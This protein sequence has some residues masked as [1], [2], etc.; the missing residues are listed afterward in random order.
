[1]P[2][3]KTY[4]TLLLCLLLIVIASNLQTGWIFLL[5]SYIFV[6]ILLSFFENKR[7]IKDVYVKRATSVRGEAGKPHPFIYYVKNPPLIFSIKEESIS[8]EFSCLSENIVSVEIPLKRGIYELNE[9]QL[10]TAYPSGWF[11]SLKTINSYKRITIWP[12]KD[13]IS[14]SF[15]KEIGLAGN[16]EVGYRSKKGSE[17][18]GVREFK[19]GDPLKKIH[20]KK[21]A[22]KTQLYVREETGFSAKKVLVYLNNHPDVPEELFEHCVSCS[23]TI[24]EYLFSI[25]FKPVL[26]CFSKNGLLVVE[27]DVNDINDFLAG[28]EQVN[29]NFDFNSSRVEL[30]G[31][32]QEK[33]A[34][35]FITST[36]WQ[37][38]CLASFEDSFLV[39]VYKKGEIPVKKKTSRLILVEVDGEERKWIY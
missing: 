27:K 25:G 14:P 20:W 4:G 18:A 11:K 29:P 28:V 21:S 23:R 5:C 22:G 26:A 7:L 12:E 32:I 6:D 9:I 31:L 39:Y 1:M 13:Q 19:P 30:E 37:P 34:C 35:M 17:Y 38:K 36:D 2:T 15:A 10:I 3:S 8:C 16:I 33:A 24:S